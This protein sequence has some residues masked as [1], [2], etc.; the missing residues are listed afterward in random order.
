MADYGCIGITRP[1]TYLEFLENCL[2]WLP[3]RTTLCLIL[4]ATRFID[5][6]NMVG[7][8]HKRLN[9]A[10]KDF[11]KTHP[12]IRFI[13]VDDFIEDS[14]DYL[15]GI[16]H[17]SARVYYGIAQAIAKAIRETTGQ[18]VATRPRGTVRL[19]SVVMRL[20]R[21]LVSSIKPGSALYSSLKGIYDRIY[22]KRS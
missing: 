16:N 3:E 10:I 21:S 14:S 19:D 13:E 4:G 8:R 5:E 7:I 20:R 12:R 1:E 2:K 9:D 6:R 17:F 18:S 15:D 11:A 22:K